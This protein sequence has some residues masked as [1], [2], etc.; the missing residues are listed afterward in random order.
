MSTHHSLPSLREGRAT[1][2]GGL[3]LVR[4]S[5]FRCLDTLTCPR[6]S[7]LVTSRPSRRE[8]DISTIPLVLRCVD[9]N[10]R[11]ES[12]DFCLPPLRRHK[13]SHQTTPRVISSSRQARTI[14]ASRI[15]VTRTTIPVTR[16][17]EPGRTFSVTS[18]YGWE[19]YSKRARPPIGTIPTA[20]KSRRCNPEN[21]YEPRLMSH[22]WN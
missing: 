8:G 19:E 22:G 1:A 4:C 5:L 7:P 21:A 15:S 2:R 13:Y 16:P 11:R 18:Y 9:T 17:N 10:A 20:F 6:P 14:G 3:L 12:D